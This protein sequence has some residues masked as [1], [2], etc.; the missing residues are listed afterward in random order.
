MNPNTPTNYSSTDD[1]M[2]SDIYKKFSI[3]KRTIHEGFKRFGY[4]VHVSWRPNFSFESENYHDVT[5]PFVLILRFS[6]FT[7]FE[8]LISLYTLNN[9]H[10]F[11]F[12][13]FLNS[14]F[15]KYA[16]DKKEFIKNIKFDRKQIKH[17][18]KIQTVI[19]NLSLDI[20]FEKYDYK[21]DNGNGSCILN[22]KLHRE[23]KKI[24]L[25]PTLKNE[26][27]E[28][29]ASRYFLDNR[30]GILS[31]YYDI[32]YLDEFFSFE[33]FNNDPSKCAETVK[34]LRY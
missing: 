11:R 26:D 3:W 20:R 19:Q 29:I 22:M 32:F 28:F 7:K 9:F 14:F 15:L 23:S 12:E 5:T 16:E 18:K 2:D 27:D 30:K 4:N 13:R 6:E 17:V 10:R 24:I 21:F 31:Y 33:E 25:N 1:S 8:Y 34:M